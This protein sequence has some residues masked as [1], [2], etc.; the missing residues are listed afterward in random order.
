MLTLL[1]VYKTAKNTAC[2]CDATDIIIVHGLKLSRNK[3]SPDFKLRLDRAISLHLHHQAYILVLGGVTG[4]NSL[5]EAEA[6]QQY[7][8]ENR[9]RRDSILM[10]CQSRHT[11]ENLS[12]AR[13][14]IAEQGLE[15]CTLLSNRY[16]LA[17]VSALAKGMNIDITLVA[18]EKAFSLTLSNLTLFL[19][20]AFFLHWYY[21]GK[22]WSYATNNTHIINRIS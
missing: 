15:H 13:N 1:R 6:G 10:E 20:E 7:L 2:C 12:E 17:R 3:I 8:I 19:A 14:I 16:H 5:S 4:N 11:L 22:Y 18:A 9:V 21:T